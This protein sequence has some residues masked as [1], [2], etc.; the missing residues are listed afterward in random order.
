[1]GWW[2]LS[3]VILSDCKQVKNDVVTDLQPVGKEKR[4]KRGRD[5]KPAK[6]GRRLL[7]HSHPVIPGLTILADTGNLLHAL[8]HIPDRVPH[9]DGDSS[10]ISGQG[11]PDDL[12][13]GRN[14]PVL[15]DGL[16]VENERIEL[17]KVF[18]YFGE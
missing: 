11:Q 4:S 3:T 8:N 7:P 18:N 14:V 5:R 10:P 17:R 13:L 16:N 9:W 6:L 2:D 1:W 12:V 15:A